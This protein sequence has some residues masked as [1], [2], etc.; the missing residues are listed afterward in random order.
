LRIAIAMNEILQGD[1]L[2][3]LKTLPE[4]SVDC[5]VTSPPYW[6]L[7]DYGTGT[8]EGGDENCAHENPNDRRKARPELPN[9]LAGWAERDVTI[10]RAFEACSCGATKT[11]LQLGLEK[12]PE[13]F[14]ENMVLV[15]R[16]VKR[17]LKK[18]GTLWLNIGDSYAAG[19]NGG[20]TEKQESNR[21]TRALKGKAKKAPM[22]MK[23]KDLCGIPWMLAF[24]LRSDG[25]Y[26]R[27]DIIWSKPNPMP[28]SVTDRC[29]K[30]HEYVFL[31]AK[32]R[33]YYFDNEAIKEKAV[34]VQPITR[35]AGWASGKDHTAAGWNTEKNRKKFDPSQAGGGSNI[36][37]HSGARQPNGEPYQYAIDGTRNK[38]SVWNVNTQAF[39]EAHF[40]TYP[41]ELIAPMIKAGCPPHGI[42]LDP[43]FGSGT[44]GL[45]AQKLGRNYIGI[46]LNP[47]YIKIAENRLKQKP[48]L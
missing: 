20:G 44:T 1:S 45:V 11:D 28:E 24:A 4:N 37:G 21:G 17:V 3:V 9:P 48:L 16:E 40:A 47:E 12:T 41:E 36:G 34:T 23:P 29:T 18:E 7:R 5:C 13:E 38:R 35:P 8:W 43:F 26:L 27:Q 15:F 42:V 19:G 31:M 6:G 30:S 32:S 10:R 39:P 25:W 2:T 22:G 46:E 14:I 33:D